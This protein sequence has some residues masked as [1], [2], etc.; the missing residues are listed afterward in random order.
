M[1]CRYHFLTMPEIPDADTQKILDDMKKDGLEVP[2]AVKPEEAEA[3]AKA[4]AEEKAQ[5]EAKAKEE[6]DKKAKEEA[7]AK[8]KAEA[9][10]GS[11]SD[12]DED[13]DDKEG[14]KVLFIPVGQVKAEKK[15]LE[16]KLK[17]EF[18]TQIDGLKTTITDLTTK[19]GSGVKTTG[20]KTEI[21]QEITDEVKKVAEK[22]GVEPEMVL[23]IIA[24]VPK[25]AEVKPTDTMSDEDKETLKKQRERDEAEHQT[26][27]FNTE[28]V[29]SDEKPGVA[30]NEEIK[31]LVED[32]GYTLEQAKAK[33]YDF[34][35]STAGEAYAKIPLSEILQMKLSTLLPQKKKSAESGRGGTGSGAGGKSDKKGIPT[36]E[37][38]DAMSDEEFLKQ[39]NEL[40]KGSGMEIR[41]VG[42]STK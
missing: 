34:V 29:G 11:K 9:E 35:F 27:L 26:N 42:S 36:K 40:G 38:M 39:S 17:G 15:A 32:R 25:P 30:N 33:L 19:L 16:N 3:K 21:K 1:V 4:E 14:R 18:Q 8:A 13:D 22:W 28:F 7:E 24:L 6:A 37:E 12:K 5:S 2:G 41:R 10:A 31:K 20:E 23:E